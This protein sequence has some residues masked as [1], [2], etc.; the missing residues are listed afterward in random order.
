[1][2]KILSKDFQSDKVLKENIYVFF[3]LDE[4]IKGSK[5]FIENLQKFL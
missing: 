4:E 5:L 3:G 1:L 2:I